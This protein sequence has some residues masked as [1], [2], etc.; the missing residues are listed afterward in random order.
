MK[1]KSVKKK[2]QGLVHE[3]IQNKNKIIGACKIL[4]K[5]GYNTL[6]NT[7]EQ[8]TGREFLDIWSVMNR[9]FLLDSLNNRFWFSQIAGFPY[10]IVDT[11]WWSPWCLFLWFSTLQISTSKRGPISPQPGDFVTCRLSDDLK[12]KF[13]DLHN[14][15]RGQVQ[16][17]AADMEYLVS[18]CAVDCTITH[19]RL[20]SEQFSLVLISY[21][22]KVYSLTEALL[23]L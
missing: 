6:I 7:T 19:V 13:L 5:P 15:L 9:S 20:E 8:K 14:T 21:T 12:E 16:P 10:T 1:K 2:F 22:Q 23:R 17:S 3:N 4:A 11:S 18:F